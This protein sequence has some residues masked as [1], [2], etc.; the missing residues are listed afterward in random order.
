MRVTLRT[1]ALAMIALG[2]S[3][4]YGKS[5]SDDVMALVPRDSALVLV[6][7][8]F[9]DRSR[10]IVD[11]PMFA[12]LREIP[13]V[14]AWEKS[15]RGEGLRNSRTELEAAL[16]IGLPTLRDEILGDCAILA[17]QPPPKGG[18]GDPSGLLITRF[19]DR[20]AITTLIKSLNDAEK[21][22][23][24]LRSVDESSRAGVKYWRRTFAPGTK[25]DEW[26]A[27]LPG[28]L[29]AWSNSEAVLQGVI[30]RVKTR[31]G[32]GSQ[33]SYKAI[34]D[35]LPGKSLA[36]LHLDPKAIVRAG[37]EGPD[38]IDPKLASLLNT[39]D[40][41]GAALEW[42]DGPIL[43]LR[44][45]FDPAHLPEAIRPSTASRP[46]DPSSLGGVPKSAIAVATWQ[47]NL[48]GW[49]DLAMDQI[50]DADRPRTDA[51]LTAAKGMFLGL[52]PRKEILPAL[53]PGGVAFVSVRE[54]GRG[55]EAAASIHIADRKD[56]GEALANGLRT[57]AALA[58][59]DK[60]RA[61]GGLSSVTVAEK[62]GERVTSL[63]VGDRRPSFGANA[64][65]LVLG[66]DPDLVG[67]LLSGTDPATGEGGSGWSRLRDAEFSGSDGFA[68]IDL[69]MLDT[70][71][72]S[73]RDIL[74]K[75][76]AKARSGSE[77]DAARDIAR[78]LELIK[79]FGHV[80]A[81]WDVA[82]DGTSAHQ[83]IGL[84][85]RTAPNR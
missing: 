32:L 16:G 42:R 35:G 44:E 40:S 22:G 55:L 8:D 6:V 33:A 71:A 17:W 69:A 48:P 63:T 27:L 54:D 80:F 78:A 23:G 12:R 30:D 46:L 66:T 9:R 84:I 58:S 70:F 62:R 2:I 18:K 5:S 53:S 65:R 74:A 39:L 68:A 57:M 82:R 20:A 76:V 43:H 72:T 79:P 52:D 38:P 34:R 61:P 37:T 24:A 15:E 10:E 77:S 7:E 25:P 81:A 51:M 14:R 73:N 26:Y 28:D 41:F 85:G 13:A 60:D 59:L 50:P 64:R 1:A 36:R 11:S 45:M 4:A 31:D 47:W 29:F 56:V 19:R 21:K 49:Y 75:K 3:S 83:M 67:R